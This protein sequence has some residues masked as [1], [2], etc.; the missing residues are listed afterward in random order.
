[1][2]LSTNLRRFLRLFSAIAILIPL[3]AAAGEYETARPSA[4]DVQITSTPAGVEFATWGVTPAKPAPTL[5]ILS[6]NMKDSLTRGSFLRAG[7]LLAPKGYLCVTID[8]PNHGAEA[9]PGYSNLS[10][11]GK[12]AAAG[13]DFVAEFNDRMKQVVDHLIT[14]GLTDPERI[15]VT[16][17]SRGGFMAIRYAAFD[18]RIKCAVGYAPVTDLRRLKEFDLALDVPSV[19]SMSL[20]AYVPQ[21]VGRPILIMIGDRDERVGTDAAYLFAR[22][23]SEAAVATDV[24]SQV[25]LR[26]LSE[27]RGH[28]MPSSVGLSAARWIYRI[29]EGEE[30]PTK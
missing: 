25:E 6:G 23:L 1:M 26:I 19:D 18:Q 4:D 21:L 22:K 8:L 5:I 3:M 11:W 27:P 30:L 16:G 28:S 29:L 2:L 12:R 14:Q 9:K 13:D 20:E 10:G 24:P 15:A 7:E 17:T